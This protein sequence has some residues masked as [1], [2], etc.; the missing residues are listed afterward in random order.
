MACFDD[1]LAF[2]GGLLL[3]LNNMRVC[4]AAAGVAAALLLTGCGSDG[5][6]DK[7]PTGAQAGTGAAGSTGATGG[8]AKPGSLEGGWISMNTPGKGVVLTV[9]GPVAIVIETETGVTCQG[10]AT[11][12][13]LTLQCPS[14]GKRTKGKVES[15]DATS[16][17]VAWDGVGTDTFQKSEPGKLPS[18]PPVPK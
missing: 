12:K 1:Q 17:K 4:V 18:F 11:G 9:K 14:G 2:T 8:D 7:K 15:V 13:D 5:A 10:T 3:V 16:L 6:T